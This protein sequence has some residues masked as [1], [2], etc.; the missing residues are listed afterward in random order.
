MVAAQ[1]IVFGGCT[2]GGNSWATNVVLAHNI[3]R[4]SAGRLAGA[5]MHG[6]VLKYEIKNK[7]FCSSFRTM[8]AS[9]RSVCAQGLPVKV[10]RL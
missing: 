3:I 1:V 10:Q 9:R 4:H 5:R 7:F 6:G 8:H 2:T